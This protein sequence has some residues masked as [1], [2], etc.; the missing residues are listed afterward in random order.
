MQS[1][2]YTSFS[3][4]GHEYQASQIS[5]SADLLF[6]QPIFQNHTIFE[7]PFINEVFIPANDSMV[8]KYYINPFTPNMIINITSDKPIH[9]WSKLKHFQ[10]IS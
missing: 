10:S 9:R 8:F 6:L 2:R 5:E 3:D 4:T 1:R 7:A